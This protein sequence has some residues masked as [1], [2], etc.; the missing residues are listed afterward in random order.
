MPTVSVTMK[1]PGLDR[2]IRQLANTD[3][4]WGE[5]A[6]AWSIL[7]RSFVRQRFAKFAKGGGDW[8]PL[9]PATIKRRRQGKKAGRAPE[10]LRDTGA[11]FAALQP[12]IS[13]GILQQS[14][15]TFGMKI[16]LGGGRAYKS[17]PT[18]SQ[19]A[20]FHHRGS[21][22]LPKRE[23]LVVPDANTQKKMAEVGKKIFVRHINER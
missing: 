9:A 21:G 2:M 16:F 10:I 3:K 14:V 4:A 12:G 8:P 7:Y 6:D 19:V 5:I 13:G 18:L 1:T 17:G 11:M 15:R 20:V 22:R 23:I